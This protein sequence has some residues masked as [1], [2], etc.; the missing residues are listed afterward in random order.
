MRP[1]RKKLYRIRS[2]L[3]KSL[4]TLKR[5]SFTLIELLIVIAILGILAAA[6]LVAINP[7]KRMGQTRDAQRKNDLGQLKN[8]LEAYNAIYGSYPI[9]YCGWPCWASD[10]AGWGDKDYEGPNGYIPNL[11]PGEIKKLPQD[12]RGNTPGAFGE[13][14][15]EQCKDASG[16]DHSGYFYQSNG[17]DYKVMAHCTP[18]NYPQE[19]PFIDPSRPWHAYAVWSS[20]ASKNW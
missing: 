8:A 2:K 4:T 9:P 3:D 10:A 16:P 1:A 17:T 14:A 20:D 5:K 12:P 6:V 7:L 15:W 13:L 18:E 19:D 11:A